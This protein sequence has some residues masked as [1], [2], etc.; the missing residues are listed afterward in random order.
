MQPSELSIETVER[1][2]LTSPVI[3]A[4]CRLLSIDHVTQEQALIGM[5]S[6][7]QEQVETLQKALGDAMM[8]QVEP[9]TFSRASEN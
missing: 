3:S 1:L 2:A 4:Y 5:V 6:A 9:S 7:L 8:R